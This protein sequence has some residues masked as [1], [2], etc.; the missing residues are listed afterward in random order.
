MNRTIPVKRKTILCA[1]LVLIMILIAAAM[2]PMAAQAAENPLSITVKQTI[3][4]S[5]SPTETTF[6]YRLSPLEAGT[7]VPA[8]STETGFLFT[9]TG[10]GSA[11]IGPL[12]YDRQ[13]VYRYKLFQLIETEKTGWTYDKRVYTVEVYVGEAL[14]VSFVVINADGTKA[15]EIRFINKY[16]ELPT[17]PPGPA[18]PPNPG[19]GKPGGEGKP[20]PFTGDDMETVLFCTMFAL[21]GLAAIGSVVYLIAGKKRKKDE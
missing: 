21:G 4:T 17:I 14:N 1:A 2:A 10:N 18:N 3:D 13:G 6:K 16:Q 9:I 11:N 19:G 5:L 8:G 12:R 7:P 15:D 20:G